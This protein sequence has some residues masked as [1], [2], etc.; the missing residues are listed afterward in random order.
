M[1]PTASSV[2]P[3]ISLLPRIRGP[4]PERNRRSPTRL[5]WGNEPTGSGARELSKDLL[6]LKN[7]NR[8]LRSNADAEGFRLQTPVSIR[9][10]HA[11]YHFI[12][13]DAPVPLREQWFHFF[14]DHGN[15]QIDPG[16]CAD[17]FERLP[18]CHDDDL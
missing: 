7:S 4:M 11:P 15:F 16:K 14:G 13:L 3:G 8:E 6:M 12:V 5:A 1:L 17:R 2:T 18:S 9:I 10:R